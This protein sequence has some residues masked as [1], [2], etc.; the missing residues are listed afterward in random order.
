MTKQSDAFDPMKVRL[1]AAQWDVLLALAQG[2][3]DWRF[4]G[5]TARSL[6]LRGLVT[7]N[8]RGG[9]ADLTVSG[10]ITLMHR[11]R[12]RVGKHTWEDADHH[13][14]QMNAWEK[15]KQEIRQNLADRWG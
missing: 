7:R 4:D 5:G 1:S 12:P 9:L 2:R 8:G 14:Q 15:W 6:I 11:E 10:A 3:S 13:E